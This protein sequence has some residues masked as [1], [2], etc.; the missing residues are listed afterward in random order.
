MSASQSPKA[1]LMDKEEDDKM[2]SKYLKAS[3][4]QKSSKELESGAAEELLEGGAIVQENF[5]L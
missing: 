2:Q 3:S 1:P 5:N 4:S